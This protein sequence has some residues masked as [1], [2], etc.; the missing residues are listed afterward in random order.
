MKEFY[1]KNAFT[2]LSL[3]LFAL[4]FILGLVAMFHSPSAKSVGTA[5]QPTLGTPITPPVTLEPETEPP[6][7]DVPYIP[8]DG[9]KFASPSG[10]Q[11][12]YGVGNI[13]LKKT[14]QTQTAVYAV[15]SSDCEIGKGDIA[16][17]KKGVGVAMLNANL[18]VTKTL[19]IPSNGDSFYV[20]S[21]ETSEGIVIVT[22]NSSN[23][24][25]VNIVNRNLSGCT[26]REMPITVGQSAKIFPLYQSN[27]F[28]VFV[29]YDGGNCAFRYKNGENAAQKSHDRLTDIV[30]VIGFAS[31][32]LVFAN[33]DDGYTIFEL[34]NDTLS[35]KP[36]Y[37]MGNTLLDAIPITED[38]Q[39]FYILFERPPIDS[40]TKQIKSIARKVQVTGNNKFDFATAISVAEAT[41][42]TAIYHTGGSDF[43]IVCRGGAYNGLVKLS[44]AKSFVFS[45]T[46]NLSAVYTNILDGESDPLLASVYLL[47]SEDDGKAAFLN[48]GENPV[49][50]GI[51]ANAANLIPFSNQF[52]IAYATSYYGYDA[53]GFISIS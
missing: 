31:S 34:D 13:S 32:M 14:H 35:L 46:N 17:G 44:C 37:E 21:Q 16:G 26:V 3:S 52:I 20:T 4:I 15:V 10:T 30:R 27:S 12:L 51:T 28:V 50:L 48:V 29:K 9:I 36:I 53:V 42:F 19:F 38:G 22:A 41:D 25:F 47:V 8:F 39:L 33:T 40:R 11:L 43:W 23:R 49:P 1:R 6:T 24:Y 5:S 18:A 45:S 2:I 7:I